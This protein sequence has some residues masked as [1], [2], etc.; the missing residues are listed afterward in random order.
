[1]SIPLDQACKDE[2]CWE[3]GAVAPCETRSCFLNRLNLPL[4]TSSPVLTCSCLFL[5]YPFCSVLLPPLLHSPTYLDIFHSA[6]A[7]TAG[8]S[9]VSSGQGRLS[10]FCLPFCLSVC[11]SD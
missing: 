4:P 6:K 11:L 9:V 5:Q 2:V 1:M 3:R 10:T 8:I 7:V